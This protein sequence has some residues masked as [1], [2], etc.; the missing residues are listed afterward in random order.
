MDFIN[1]IYVQHDVNVLYHYHLPNV[2]H[3]YVQMLNM[4]GKTGVDPSTDNTITTMPAVSTT[5]IL[6]SEGVWGLFSMLGN[7]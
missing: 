2:L 1:I 6:I 4:L 7:V 5:V 3:Q